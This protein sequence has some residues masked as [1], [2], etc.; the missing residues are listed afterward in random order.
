MQTLEQHITKSKD[1]KPVMDDIY[2]K[3]AAADLQPL[4]DKYSEVAVQIDDDIKEANRRKPKKAKT[5]KAVKDE[6]P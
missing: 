1:L 6:S 5:D 2:M 4:Y 3:T